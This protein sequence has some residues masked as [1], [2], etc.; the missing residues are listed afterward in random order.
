LGYPG[1]PNENQGID[2]KMILKWMLGKYG[3]LK[4]IGSDS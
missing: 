3:E 2:D 4:L 1:R